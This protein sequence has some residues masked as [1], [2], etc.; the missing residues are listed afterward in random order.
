M[1]GTEQGLR[2]H[3]AYNTDLF[4]ATTIARMASH[5]ETLLEGITAHP[6]RRVSELPLLT[7]SEQHQLL[8]E[9][10][11]GR[12]DYP[13]GRC[14]HHLFEVCAEQTPDA[15][16]VVCMGSQ[17]TYEEL[18]R[19]ANQL[20]HRLQ[21]LG[22]GPETPVAILAERS[23]E[24]VIGMMGV[25]KAGGAYVPMDPMYPGERLAFMLEDTQAPVLI[26]QK[27]IADKLPATQA[28]IIYLD[29]DWEKINQLSDQSI[30]QISNL[31]HIA[32]VIYTSGSTGQPKGVLIDHQSVMNHLHWRQQQFR[33]Q[34]T[35]KVLHKAPFSCDVPAWEIL[36]PFMIGACTV[37]AKPG[38]HRDSVYL[39]KL[40]AKEAI[41][42]IHF[43]PSM[44]AVFLQEPTAIKLNS[45]R[46]CFCGAET[47][48]PALQQAFFA[49]FPLVK[50]YN[51]S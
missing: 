20:A 48:T 26:T 24:M 11:G 47:L 15:D 31:N 5:L 51:V 45:L 42:T 6:E 17:L 12:A 40:I 41:T 19:R 49:Q 25:L 1:T 14:I 35:D 3:L 44:L 32:Y 16:A 8:V 9:W 30:Q 50:L 37:L 28:Q 27:Y 29:D 46:Q 34:P 4:D 10:K 36:W 13:Q 22:V 43:V 33:L 18:N 2:G 39:A 38:G 21:A 7:K 23:L